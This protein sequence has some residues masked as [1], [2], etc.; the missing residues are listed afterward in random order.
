[1][2]LLIRW[3]HPDQNNGAERSVFVARVTRAWNELKNDNRRAAYDLDRRRK[4]AKRTADR[5]KRDQKRTKAFS[6]SGG[7]PSVG[8]LQRLMTALFGGRAL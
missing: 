2:A 7:Q 3:L 6:R 4:N 5:P 1:M 8:F